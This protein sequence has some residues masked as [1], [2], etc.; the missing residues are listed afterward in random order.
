MSLWIILILCFLS[1]G[2]YIIFSLRKEKSSKIISKRDELTI[3]SFN[4]EENYHVDIEGLSCT[5]PDFWDKRRN[6]NKDEPRI[7][8][9]H[10][11]KA[12]VENNQIP[13]KFKSFT[14]EIMS[15][16]ERRAGFYYAELQVIR[17][18]NKEVH[19]I[20]NKESPW[21]NIQI[22]NNR[23]G[24]NPIEKRWSYGD[25]PDGAREIK[26]HIKSNDHRNFS[27]FI[28]DGEYDKIYKLKN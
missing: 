18:K 8:C 22:G 4:T 20:Y 14:A 13:N 19:I 17:I 10:L 23:Y 26:K 21:V 9:K 15:S 11:I 1:W 27:K 3:K 7:L 25:A 12:I 6:F 16:Y 24:Y 5:C 28:D 2:I